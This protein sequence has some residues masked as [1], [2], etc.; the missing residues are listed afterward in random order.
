[1]PCGALASSEVTQEHGLDP[2]TSS[3]VH[4]CQIQPNTSTKERVNSPK[5]AKTRLCSE[6]KPF[7]ASSRM[8]LRNNE[9][10]FYGGIARLYLKRAFH[11][12]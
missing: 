10:R 4:P 5:P 7:K 6:S 2:A 12:C 8:L 11:I 1:M 3:L 9:R